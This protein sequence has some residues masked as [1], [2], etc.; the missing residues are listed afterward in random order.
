MQHQVVM[1]TSKNL[2]CSRTME[3]NTLIIIGPAPGCDREAGVFRGALMSTP[4]ELWLL[5]GAPLATDRF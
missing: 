5:P 4:K 3:R 2:P 1:G